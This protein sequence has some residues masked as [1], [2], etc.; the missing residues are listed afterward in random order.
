MWRR[1][2]VWLTSLGSSAVLILAGAVGAPAAISQTHKHHHHH[3]HAAASVAPFK[4]ALVEDADT[5]QVLYAYN[6][7]MPWPPAS[8]A[9]MMMLL[10][11]EQQI[12]AGRFSLN[13]PVVISPLAAA[14]GGTGIAL[15]AG[16]VYPLGELMKAALIRSA[17]NAAVAVGEKIGGSVP[18]CVRLMNQEARRLGLTSTHYNTVNGL[19]PTPG[20]DVDVTDARDLAIV[21]R[22]LIH[23]T[24]LLRWSSLESCP[25]DHGEIML[26]N[27]NHLIG[28]FEGCD[29]L[30]TG[31]TFHAGFGL[32][33]TAKRGDLRLLS[34]VL[35]APSNPERFRQSARLLQWGFDNW[36][37]VTML[38][39]GQPLPVTVQVA[40][41]MR[42]KPVAG[43][44]VR[45]LVPKRTASDLHLTYD[46]P[47]VINGP[48]LTGSPLG[49][50]Q[51]REGARVLTTV[52][53]LSPLAVGVND[54]MIPATEAR[55][56]EG[57][58]PALD[59]YPKAVAAV[60]GAVEGAQ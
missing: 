27:T 18:G 7:D 30:K 46:I 41:G 1:V 14:T 17:N 10:V 4:A 9:K 20:H 51:V 25:F 58:N 26:H 44:S 11:A 56:A 54:Q 43:Q 47:P 35:G 8:M 24:D 57:R 12:Q 32:T 5:G 49:V 39:R 45:L 50:V 33:A 48:L 60:R 55:A 37:A 19:P 40:S 2:S 59:G 16:Q 53:A 23:R 3:H 22:A 21:A 42:I 29:G 36:T 38:R 15:R 28:H 52:A 31:F 13:D 34:V 6:A